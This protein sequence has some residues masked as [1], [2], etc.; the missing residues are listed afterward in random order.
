MFTLFSNQPEQPLRQ[1]LCLGAHSDD[2]EIGCGGT[3]LRLIEQ[4]PDLQWHWVVFGAT[5]D[6]RQEALA[7]ANSLLNDANQKTI[8]VQGFRDG[9]FP[10]VGTDI[11]ESFEQLKK[12]VS[13]DL[14]LTHCRHDLHQDHQLIANL[15]WNTFRNHHIWEYE[16]PKYDGDLG[17]PNVFMP[18]AESIQQR[19]ISH[20]MT[21]FSTQANKHWFT[22]ETFRSILRIRGIES[23]HQYAEA[24]YCRKLVFPV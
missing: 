5:G 3:I 22:E 14:I 8:E 10:Y 20:L 16:I 17:S 18:L 23:N 9:F 13:P 24:F 19:K 4:F 2:I 11:K 7:S 6:R 1:V 21:H 12:T 15:T